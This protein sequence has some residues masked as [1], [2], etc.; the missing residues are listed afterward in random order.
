MNIEYIIL[1]RYR[2]ADFITSET[3]I[4][5]RLVVDLLCT[6]YLS[7]KNIVKNIREAYD[8]MEIDCPL[9][10]PIILVEINN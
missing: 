8:I 10:V 4:C 6:T 9:Q 7:K 1:E 2:L 3:A 5:Q